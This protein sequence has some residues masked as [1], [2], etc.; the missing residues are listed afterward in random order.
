LRVQALYALLGRQQQRVLR[1]VVATAAWVL[2]ILGA[3]MAFVGLQTAAI[4]LWYWIQAGGML[5]F[6][7]ALGMW[8]RRPVLLRIPVGGHRLSDERLMRL[9][10]WAQVLS[11][12]VALAGLAVAVLALVVGRS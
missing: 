4:P 5:V 1:I 7:A 9:A 12:P 3:L 2:G 8:L 11:L 10:A 6:A